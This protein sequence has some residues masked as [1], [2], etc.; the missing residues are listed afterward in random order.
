MSNQ[1]IIKAHNSALH[2]LKK[3][4][5]NILLSSGKEPDYTLKLWD[6]SQ[7]VLKINQNQS[8]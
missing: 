3:T 1:L 6:L 4:P 7:L 5:D 2:L 8:L